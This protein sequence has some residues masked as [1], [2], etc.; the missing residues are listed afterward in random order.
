MKDLIKYANGRVGIYKITNI[1]NGKVYVGSSSNIGQ[2][3]YSHIGMLKKGSHHS[4]YLQQDWDEINNP[5]AFQYEIIEECDEK[6]LLEIEQKY[7][8]K[9]DSCKK[10]YN[11]VKSYSSKA[12][13]CDEGKINIPF[14]LDKNRDR[15]IF[16]TI[17]DCGSRI[18]FIKNAIYYYIIAINKGEVMDRFYPYKVNSVRQSQKDIIRSL[19]R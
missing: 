6:N 8:D 7:I 1:S 14:K 4:R 3:W 17:K 5:D 10:G 13:R 11:S 19:L 2:R 12:K 15:A 9:L 16:K 18:D